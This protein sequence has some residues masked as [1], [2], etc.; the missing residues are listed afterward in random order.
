MAHALSS[1]PA[2][3]LVTIHPRACTRY[4]GSAAQLIAEGLI[5]DGFQWP[6]RDRHVSFEVGPF[7]HWLTRCRPDGIKGPKS[8]WVDGDHWCLQRS[9][10]A[11]AGTGWQ[12]ARIYEKKMEL[13]D[14]VRRNTPEWER[15]FFRA[16]ETQKDA[17]YQAFRQQ[18]LGEPRRRG[19]P[20]KT[21]NTQKGAHA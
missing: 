17:R 7:T 11:D 3:L 14:I 20:A 19:R 6:Q 4:Y 2:D 16:L 21:A 5:P 12:A 8:V 10:T 9:L 13:A 15:L 1:A 18:L